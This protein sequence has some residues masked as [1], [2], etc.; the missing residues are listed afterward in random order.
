MALRSIRL[1]AVE[2]VWVALLRAVNLG[3]R[4][5]VPMA[6]LRRVFETAGYES[7]RTFIQSGNVLFEHEAPDRAAL[8]AAVADAFGVQTAIVLRTA[9]QIRKVAGS[10]P[11]GP[12]TSKSAVA[13]LAEQPDPAG[14]RELAKLDIAPDR[15]KVAGSDVFLH[16][17]NG[18]QGARLT[19]AL[20][21]R[22]LGVAATAR[23][24]R[25][26]ARLA[27]LTESA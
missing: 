27:E 26:V 2:H 16:Y 22:R 1:A 12:D 19:A 9:A 18:F 24:W 11:F 8:E 15:V 3:A 21:E 4:N 14:V 5:K 23:N 7:V 10:H 13:F 17:P 20:L 6:E 25:T